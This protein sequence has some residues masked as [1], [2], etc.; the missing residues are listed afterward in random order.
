MEKE[1]VYAEWCPWTDVL[2]FK[3]KVNWEAAEAAAE[4]DRFHSEQ[5]AQAEALASGLGCCVPWGQNVPLGV[6]G[7]MCTYCWHH[8][9]SMT[10]PQTWT[11]RQASKEWE[12]LEAS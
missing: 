5:K 1:C 4:K 9:K 6:T 10:H 12:H 2:T 7:G 8:N 3:V 11:E